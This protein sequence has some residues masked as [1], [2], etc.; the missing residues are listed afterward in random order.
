MKDHAERKNTKLKGS[1][2]W[3]SSKMCLGTDPI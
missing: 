2:Q 1:Y 3:S